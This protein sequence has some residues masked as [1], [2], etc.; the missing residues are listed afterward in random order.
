MG[1]PFFKPTPENTPIPESEDV[2]MDGN[3]N[4]IS[5]EDMEI[6]ETLYGVPFTEMA[7]RI[8]GAAEYSRILE[9]T[10]AR[11]AFIDAIKQK[12][13]EQRPSDIQRATEE[14]NALYMT[15]PK[16]RQVN[17]DPDT[18]PGDLI[19]ETGI[20]RDDLRGDELQ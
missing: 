12:F 19:K 11:Q 14:W 1:E 10:D 5:N 17:G 4:L 13:Q 9:K 8:L 6:I 15:D 16:F 7:H 2:I 18:D 20:T 3:A